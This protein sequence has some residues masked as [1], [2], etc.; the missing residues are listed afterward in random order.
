VPQMVR[1]GI[2]LN[3]ACILVLTLAA[4]SGALAIIGGIGP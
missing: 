1:A 2:T 4:Y 3:L